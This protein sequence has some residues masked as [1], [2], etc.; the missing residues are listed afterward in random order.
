M[1]QLLPL[2]IGLLTLFPVLAFAEQAPLVTLDAGTE[3]PAYREGQPVMLALTLHNNA[4]ENLFTASAFEASAFQI[5]VMTETG[6]PVLRTAV[7]ERIL[8]PPMSVR[9][10]SI[11]AFSPG[12]TLSYRFNLARLFDLSRAGGYTVTVSRRFRPW[13]LPRSA[14]DT[15]TQEIAL[16]AGPLKV[17]MEE[18]AS[19]RSGPVS[20]VTPP[21]R[22][23][24]LYVIGRY[25]DGVSH[26]LVREDGSLSFSLAYS[27]HSSPRV[28]KG[29][30]SLA[31]TPDGRFLY[32]SNSTDYTVA[33]FRIG[34][35]G[36]LFPLSP[37]TVPAHPFPGSL[38]MDPKGR[39][40]YNLSGTV[41]AIGHTGRLTVTASAGNDP[42]STNDAS[43]DSTV[44]RAYFGAINSKG[45]CLYTS[46]GMS[47]LASDGEVIALPPPTSG[48]YGPN[49]GNDNA[50]ALSPTDNFAFVGVSTTL[51]SAFFDKIVPMRVD[52]DGTFIQIPG[53]T[54]R[55]VAPPLP[56][57]G[58]QP[59]L[60]KA[61]AVDPSGRFLIVV[62]PG[63]LDCY[64]IKSD[65]SLTF[66][67]MTEQRGDLTS[68]SFG[69]VGSLV[70]ALNRNP[71]SLTAFRLDEKHGLVSSGLDVT[72][73]LPFDACLAS[74]VAPTPLKWGKAVGGVMVSASLPAD[75]LPANAPVVLTVRLKNMTKRP[76]RLGAAGE[77]MTS[78]RLAV[79]GPQRQFPG[80]LRGGGEPLAA[81]VPLLAAGHDLLDAPSPSTVPVILPP[82]GQRQ[83]RFVLSRL[84]DLTV[85]GN[86]TVQ[87][88]RSLPSGT[89]V[90]SP[91]VPFLLDGPFNGRVRDGKYQVQIL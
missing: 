82:G 80:V 86:Y 1:R 68:V 45:T 47:R 26:Y 11:A 13:V 73:D 61:L 34:N 67:S 84:A 57:P 66:L 16:S 37:P 17:Q 60:C 49:G 52:A 8:T 31:T 64:R 59:F 27:L 32:A 20:F 7:G 75:V 14:G 71:S 42:P 29:T 88:T 62:N 55:P 2:L 22:Q 85:A 46:G 21:S 54:Q 53:A 35:N 90:T 23:P 3:Q 50:I 15:P 43:K 63:F 76:I 25:D 58:F 41:Y 10:N 81:L 83:Y 74:A 91:V 51:S 79:V 39:F 40:L 36:V 5:A 48:L 38:L 28:A 65:G 44:V 77:G 4:A 12:Q 18:D 69:P 9:A 30:D 24:Y 89:V 70:Y 19:A 87:I 78:F 56:R 33:Q 72:N 6:E